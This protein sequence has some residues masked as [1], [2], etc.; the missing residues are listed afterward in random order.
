MCRELTF[1]FSSFLFSTFITFF[2]VFAVP[3]R[4]NHKSHGPLDKNDLLESADVLSKK[5]REEFSVVFR[6]FR[7]LK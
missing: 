7:G 1:S 4:K 5:N 2:F 6:G 3:K